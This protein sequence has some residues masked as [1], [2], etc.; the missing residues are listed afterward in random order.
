MSFSTTLRRSAACLALALLATGCA[1]TMNVVVN[2]SE[3][4]K[5]YSTA[6]VVTHGGKSVDMDTSFTGALQKHGLKVLQGET[7]PANGAA[8]MVVVYDDTWR[9]DLA[10]YLLSLNVQFYDGKTGSLLA[11]SQWHNSP[12]HGFPKEDDVVNQVING[13]FAKL[14]VSAPIAMT[15][16]S[17][18]TGT[19]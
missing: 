17:S 9:W 5:S 19:K 16:S 8:D 2:P 12:A 11:E 7:K 13:T 4:G 1:T 10:M 6:F 15:P 14:N 3:E 18:T